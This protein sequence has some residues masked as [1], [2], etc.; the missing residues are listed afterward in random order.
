MARVRIPD[1]MRDEIKSY[2]RN[3]SE[4]DTQSEFV[5]DAV[6]RLFDN[7]RDPEAVDKEEVQDMIDRKLEE[8]L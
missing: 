7:K 8:K 2:V 1:S 5:K 3:S 4:Y 6:R